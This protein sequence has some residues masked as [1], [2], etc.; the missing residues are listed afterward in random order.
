MKAELAAITE[1]RALNKCHRGS[2]GRAAL[3]NAP[4]HFSMN[5]HVN[6]YAL[7]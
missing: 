7:K 4:S 5:L 3:Y 6:G 1:Q 2:R